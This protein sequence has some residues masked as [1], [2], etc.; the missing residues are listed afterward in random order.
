MSKQTKTLTILTVAMLLL[1]M[2]LLGI[3]FVD[4]DDHRHGERAKKHRGSREHFEQRM[5]KRLGLN[6]QQKEAYEKLHTS[7][8]KEFWEISKAI[9]DVKKKIGESLADEQ[10]TE[11]RELLTV[12]DSL[13]QVREQKYFDHTQAIFKVFA[14]EQRQ[15]FLETLNKVGN[16]HRKS[17]RRRRD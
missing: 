4:G 16:E 9:F 15:K 11:A 12:L 17:R 13:H 10:E 1:N 5:S 6:E 2:V 7:H 14:P 3:I 8:K